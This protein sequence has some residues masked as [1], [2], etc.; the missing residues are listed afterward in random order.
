M[1][2]DTLNMTDGQKEEGEKKETKD[3]NRLVLHKLFIYKF[4]PV[5]KINYCWQ[6]CHLPTEGTVM[7]KDSYMR[8]M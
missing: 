5:E 2:F 1:S 4:D 8:T 3:V 6:K 7:W